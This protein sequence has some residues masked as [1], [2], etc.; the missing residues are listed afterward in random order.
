[1]TINEAVD[2]SLVLFGVFLLPM[3]FRRIELKRQL[4]KLHE[5]L[6]GKTATEDADVR[7]RSVAARDECSRVLVLVALGRMSSQEANILCARSVAS[8]GVEEFLV[9]PLLSRNVRLEFY[10]RPYIAVPRAIA[11]VL[12]A[13][14]GK[15]IDFAP[16]TLFEALGWIAVVAIL[17]A[18]LF[19]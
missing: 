3:A 11:Q 5:L 14:L 17:A 16:K 6:E 10:G 2:I 13:A 9:D 12:V 19:K 18:I 7:S 8:A 4:E 15:L 1:M